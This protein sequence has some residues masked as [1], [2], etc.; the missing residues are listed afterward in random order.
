M[1]YLLSLLVPTFGITTTPIKKY[2]N[3]LNLPTTIKLIVRNSLFG[4]IWRGLQINYTTDTQIFD[5]LMMKTKGTNFTILYIVYVPYMASRNYCYCMGQ[6][7]KF[8]VISSLD[9]ILVVCRYLLYPCTINRA[10]EYCKYN[11]L[12]FID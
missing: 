6:D 5:S 4:D 3:M 9:V 2:F 7:I 10:V 8:V 1:F 12:S 11:L